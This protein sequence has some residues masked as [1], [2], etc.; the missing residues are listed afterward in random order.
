MLPI[1]TYDW[2]L[3]PLF[4]YEKIMKYYNRYWRKNKWSKEKIKK[5]KIR[6]DKLSV[7]NRKKNDIIE[8]KAL[9]RKRKKAIKSTRLLK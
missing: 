4:K 3:Y 5:Y 1:I 8:Q 2:V 9:I 6:M 7:I